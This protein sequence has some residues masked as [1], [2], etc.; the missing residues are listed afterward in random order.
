MLSGIMLFH[1]LG[2][3]PMPGCSI[4][5][6]CGA[7]LSGKWAYIAGLIPVSSLATGAY[8]TLLLGLWCIRPSDPQLHKTG[9]NLLLFLCGS[10]VGIAIWFIGLQLFELHEICK[11]CMAMHTLGIII[12]VILYSISRKSIITSQRRIVPISI[13]FL[14]AAV[15]AIV[16]VLTIDMNLN[17]RGE[18]QDPLPLFTTT[19]MPVIGPA[20]APIQV[21]L[22]FDYQ[23]SH[24]RKIHVI[25]PEVAEKF[26][27]K[28]NFILLPT[29]LSNSCNYYL[30]AGPDRFAGSCTLAKAALSVWQTAPDKFQEFDSWMFEAGPE[31]WYPRKEADAIE[32]AASLIG[33]DKLAGCMDNLW[34]QSYFSKVFEL[35]GRTVNTNGGGIPR[36][37]YG[38][39]WL[40]PDSDTP[41]GL[42]NQIDELISNQ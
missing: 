15:T 41:E 23:C 7:V 3:T 34:V 1:S 12:S 17:N 18:T 30:P 21:E 28:V 24:C 26:G 38:Q 19:E 33:R 22:M 31:G 13:G 39:R 36:F 42:Y 29:P 4:D 25:L 5:S 10:I 6:G 37:V 20:D 9:W 32:M 11:Y 14:A 8:L 27:G 16:Q 35:F 40:I 2:S